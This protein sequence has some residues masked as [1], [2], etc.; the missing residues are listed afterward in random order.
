MDAIATLV[1]PRTVI[2]QPLRKTGADTFDA[3]G[4]RIQQPETITLLTSHEIVRLIWA[5][6]KV[7]IREVALEA[8]LLRPGHLMVWAGLEG[9]CHSAAQRAEGVQSLARPPRGAGWHCSWGQA[10]TCVSSGLLCYALRRVG[11]L[12][13]RSRVLRSGVQSTTGGK[14]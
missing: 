7:G 13:G 4:L 14:F 11:P 8:S 10:H 1:G 5:L 6:A 3:L 9:A 12:R 2:A